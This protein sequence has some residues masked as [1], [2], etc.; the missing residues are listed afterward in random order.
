MVGGFAIV[1]NREGRDLLG[2]G[3]EHSEIQQSPVGQDADRVSLEDT[4]PP[5]LLTKRTQKASIGLWESPDPKMSNVAPT[6]MDADIEV[7]P[8]GRM[9]CERRG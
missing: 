4:G 8:P 1:A 9:C 2:V 5:P 7:P 6:V 3:E